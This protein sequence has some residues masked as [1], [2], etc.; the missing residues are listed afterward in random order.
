MRFNEFILHINNQQG[1]LVRFD[2]ESCVPFIVCF[3]GQVK[4]ILFRK[5]SDF[6]CIPPF[7]MYHFVRFTLRLYGLQTVPVPRFRFTQD[8]VWK[9]ACAVAI[10]GQVV[11]PPALGGPARQA[12]SIARAIPKYIELWQGDDNPQI[13]RTYPASTNEPGSGVATNQWSLSNITD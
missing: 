10:R 2:V 5:A 3:P 11:R 9:V 6:H 8:V 13:R 1:A 4:H 7:L 12:G